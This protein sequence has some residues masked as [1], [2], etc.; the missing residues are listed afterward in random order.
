[1]KLNIMRRK[2]YSV[3]FEH[4]IFERC[5]AAVLG[6]RLGRWCCRPTARLS[7]WG[8]NNLYN[9]GQNHPRFC[10][11]NLKQLRKN[12]WWESRHG[13]L[14][15]WP[16]QPN[17]R[18]LWRNRPLVRMAWELGGKSI[19]RPK[20]LLAVKCR[21]CDFESTSSSL[22]WASLGKKIRCARLRWFVHLQ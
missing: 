20:A 8:D 7:A 2:R 17:H 13:V 4:N 11:F 21:L 19:W 5:T 10:C 12:R 15:T 9:L 14:S 18:Q 16:G 3:F 6:Q 1:M 22:Y